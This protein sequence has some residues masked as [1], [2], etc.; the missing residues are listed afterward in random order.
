MKWLATPITPPWGFAA[1]PTEP[2]PE[3]LYEIAKI[4][5]PDGR[6]A[7]DYL[8]YYNNIKDN[9]AKRIATYKASN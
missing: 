6:H 5:G 9:V 8:Y 3:E 7:S 4:F 2:L 1:L